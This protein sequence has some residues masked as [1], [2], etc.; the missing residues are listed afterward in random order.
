VLAATTCAAVGLLG[1]PT[2]FA[3]NSTLLSTVSTP[4]IAW[5]PLLYVVTL[6][7]GIAFDLDEVRPAGILHPVGA[8]RASIR[9]T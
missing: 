2:M 8:R 7:I 1:A 5:L 9:L 4:L 3:T 6:E